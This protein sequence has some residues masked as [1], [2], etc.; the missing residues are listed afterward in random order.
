MK[1]R[2][3][4]R[5]C[6]ICGADFNRKRRATVCSESCKAEAKRRYQAQW[7]REHAEHRR[8]YYARYH[9]AH[10]EERKRKSRERYW[11][12]R[13]QEPGFAEKL[14]KRNRAYRANPS[15][16][17]LQTFLVRKVMAEWGVDAEQAQAWIR[18]GSFPP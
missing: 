15:P 8:A 13:L 11:A 7:E 12:K 18:Q 10:Q 5:T 17:R 6:V 1:A 4:Q 2:R 3:E 14:R 16:R 9:M